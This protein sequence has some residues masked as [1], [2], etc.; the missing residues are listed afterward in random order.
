VLVAFVVGLAV[1]AGAVFQSQR[2][3]N[4]AAQQRFHRLSERVL[5]EIARRINLPVYGL[6]GARGVY[7][8]SKSVERNEFAAYVESRNLP[9]D[10]PG[11]LGFGFIKRAAR[12]DLDRFLA[13]ER[14]D[15]A[16]SFSISSR[17]ESASPRDD[18]YV[19]TEIYPLERN[20][21]TWGLDLGSNPIC[22]E[23]IERT[24]HS[25]DAAITGTVSLEKDAGG[26][27]CFLYM[28]PVYRNGTS[29]QTPEQ[30]L[31]ALT[32]VLYAQIVIKEALAGV[33]DGADDMLDFEVFD[34]STPATANM[35]FDFDQNLYGSAVAAGLH[36]ETP[37]FA[38]VSTIAVGG[39][40]WSIRTRTNPKF[41]ASIDQTITIVAGVFGL[42]LSL[43]LA[44]VIWSLGRSRTRAF[45]LA[46]NMTADLRA[47]KGLADDRSHALIASADLLRRTGELARVGGWEF[48]IATEK[49]TWSEVVY[50]IHEVP[51]GTTITVPRAIEFYAPEARHLIESAVNKAIADGSTWDLELPLITAT[52]KRI[53]VRAQGECIIEGGVTTKLC[54]AFQ[55]I[56][57]RK[58]VEELLRGSATHDKLTGLPNRSLLT[59]RLQQC[60]NRSARNL[61]RAFAILFLD[62]DRFKLTNDTL[63]HEAGDE[64]LKQIA[65]RLR[66]C[67]RSG[68]SVAF[69]EDRSTVG[70][71][72]GDEFVVVLDDIEGL[73]DAIVVADRLLKVLA[74]PYMILGHDVVSTASIGIVTGGAHYSRPDELLRDADIA[75]YE[76]KAAGKARYVV[77]DTQMHQRLQRRAE[78]EADLRKAIA[79]EQLFLVYQP[80]VS[81]AT[82][83]NHGVEVLLRWNH[84]TRGII[85]PAE[86][87]PIAEESGLILPIGE[88]VIRTACNQF[89]V[90]Q[91]TLGDLAPLSI[92]VNLSRKQLAIGSIVSK[93]AAILDETGMDPTRLNLEVTE[94]AVMNDPVGAT[95]LLNELRR[96]GIKIHMDDFGT[97]H[98]S[99]AMLHQFPID[100]LKIDRSFVANLGQGR[101][102]AALV[103]AIV[104]LA[105]NLGMSIV[106][107]GIESGEQVAMLQSID[108]EMGQGYYFSR[109]L[110]APAFEAFR[111]SA[112]QGT[113]P[114]A[115]DPDAIASAA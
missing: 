13:A 7:A 98:S 33:F 90:W 24:V 103:C 112:A 77:F 84:P 30:R 80:I 74:S 106:A 31:S 25:G 52:G 86:L 70:R 111:R 10:F 109:P 40:V 55:D 88:W 107:E 19:I 45:E 68:D 14:A 11:V 61:G 99:L 108:C 17:A 37:T 9:R 50:H 82:G 26:Q 47:A 43:L 89:K 63:G 20:R 96:T 36:A 29:P 2:A 46:N 66:A 18:L 35:L 54:G 27:D 23:A 64:L 97:G 34:G 22:R 65:L 49:L 44:I 62:F 1:T 93:V 110:T 53:W 115:T 104:Q 5:D 87:I 60:L 73:P 76:A 3:V 48:E 85:C 41:D 28:V 79:L 102:F 75:M 16:P 21:A 114:D 38:K 39:R 113:P 101:A 59:D 12:Q 15:D 8:A 42:V 91:R 57:D 92:S 67:V 71:L 72:G 4:A 94:S 78:M 69:P 95:Q 58:T 56:T 83:A 32:G 81:L 51:P 6:N 100:V 105:H